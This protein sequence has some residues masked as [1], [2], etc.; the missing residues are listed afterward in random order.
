M[1]MYR[2]ALYNGPPATRVNL[3]ATEEIKPTDLWMN[4]MSLSRAGRSTLYNSTFPMVPSIWFSRIADWVVHTIDINILGMFLL[5]LLSDLFYSGKRRYVYVI[6][7]HNN[8][9][10]GNS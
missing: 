3:K 2:R 1:L 9:T 6:S 10:L 4:R 8:Y 5:L 7:Q